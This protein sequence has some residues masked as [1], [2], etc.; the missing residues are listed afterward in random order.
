[1]ANSD[2]NRFTRTH[3]VFGIVQSGARQEHALALTHGLALMPANFTAEVCFICKGEGVSRFSDR[4]GCNYCAGT[5]LTQ[6][7]G[8]A[9]AHDSVRNQ[10]LV[11]A[12][13]SLLLDFEVSVL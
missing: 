4:F 3:H 8:A 6:C 7:N 1:M 10:V 12:S 11:A 9:P 2:R 5:G 13:R